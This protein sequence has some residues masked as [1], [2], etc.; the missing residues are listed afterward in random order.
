MGNNIVIKTIKFAL[1]PV[2]LQ[3]P[4]QNTSKPFWWQNKTLTPLMSLST[5]VIFIYLGSKELLNY[6]FSIGKFGM[7]CR[8]FSTYRTYSLNH[9]HLIFNGEVE[10]SVSLSLSLTHIREFIGLNFP[11][12]YN[13]PDFE[14]H[15]LQQVSGTPLINQKVHVV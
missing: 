6:I 14:T 3:Q 13:R 15:S 5:N 11:P 10:N 8:L 1:T 7:K 9:V 12:P 2:C 4:P